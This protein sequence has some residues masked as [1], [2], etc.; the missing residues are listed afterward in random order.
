MEHTIKLLLENRRLDEVKK[1]EALNALASELKTRLSK[2]EGYS[3]H[4]LSITPN[5]DK[6]CVDIEF[7]GTQDSFSVYPQRTKISN[8][9]S[10]K[11]VKVQDIDGS[12]I[13]GTQVYDH[14]GNLIGDALIRMKAIHNKSDYS[15]N[16]EDASYHFNSSISD[17]KR[18]EKYIAKDAINNMK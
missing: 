17:I 10:N 16:L 5:P 9:N 13:E 7:K 6:G 8:E 3:H 2:V 4:N 1:K 18:L 15:S 14:E 12:Y 11:V